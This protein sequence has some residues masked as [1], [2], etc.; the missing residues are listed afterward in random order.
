MQ[1]NEALEEQIRV[2]I[3]DFIKSSTAGLESVTVMVGEDGNV[4][5]VVEVV[6]ERGDAE[7]LVNVIIQE[8][9]KG[10]NCDAGVLCFA[11]DVFVNG[12]PLASHAP[13]VACCLGLT[14]LIAIF[15]LSG[16]L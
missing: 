12:E 11:T 16:R 3:Q 8:I 10:D 5:V 6:G 7:A 4:C 9:N 1:Y 14:V 13:Q 2:E 15:A